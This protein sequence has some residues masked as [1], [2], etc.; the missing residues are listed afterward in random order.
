MADARVLRDLAEEVE[1]WLNDQIEAEREDKAME[2]DMY[3]PNCYGA[4]WSAGSIDM[5][6]TALE[7]IRAL[8]A[9]LEGTDAPTV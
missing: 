4:G 1:Q 5:A 9:D 6:R 8:A 2:G 3:D 7:R